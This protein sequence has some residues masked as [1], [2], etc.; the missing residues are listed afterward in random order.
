MKKINL[1][2]ETPQIF[3]SF[4]V[5][6]CLSFETFFWIIA[7]KAVKNPH[8]LPIVFLISFSV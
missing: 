3:R 8:S 7:Q 6:S 1:L 4:N 2:T 5:F